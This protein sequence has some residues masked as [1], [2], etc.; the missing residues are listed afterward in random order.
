MNLKLKK[1]LQEMDFAFKVF[2]HRGTICKADKEYNIWQYL[3]RLCNWMLLI[4]MG[5]ET[6][7]FKTP[8]SINFSIF[9]QLNTVKFSSK[10]VGNRS[11]K[12][13]S[14]VKF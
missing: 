13:L 3:I 14:I 12:K 4:L 1:L 2:L 10:Y 5:L 6:L 7:V 8:I 9:K 11:Y